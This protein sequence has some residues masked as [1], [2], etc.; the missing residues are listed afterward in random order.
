MSIA[1][2]FMTTLIRYHINLHPGVKMTPGHF[3]S[4]VT[5]KFVGIFVSSPDIAS[6]CLVPK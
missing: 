3:W 6:A 1:W 2:R 5:Y 4:S